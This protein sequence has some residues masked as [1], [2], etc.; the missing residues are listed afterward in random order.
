MNT[1]KDGLVSMEST[2]EVRVDVG[3]VDTIPDHVQNKIPNISLSSNFEA[4]LQEI[5]AAIMGDV[6]SVNDD[7]RKELIMG[8]EETTLTQ[9]STMLDM[10]D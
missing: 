4:E 9:K 1:R 8:R 7:P 5:D 2:V 10:M 3:N 6:S